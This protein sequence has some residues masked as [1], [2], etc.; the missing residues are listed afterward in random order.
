MHGE[1][2]DAPVAAEAPGRSAGPPWRV[3]AIVA[4]AVALLVVAL[5]VVLRSGSKD[6]A[7]PKTPQG[8]VIEL[9]D[10]SDANA[11]TA[12]AAVH[13]FAADRATLVQLLD[14]L[15]P[16]GRAGLLASLRTQGGDWLP[17]E[18]KHW[19]FPEARLGL[20]TLWDQCQRRGLGR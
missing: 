4:L 16:A 6:G 12:C 20:L 2:A 9:L 3:I 19:G 13:T 11:R 10:T 7:E 17:A 14:T 15:P 5:L 1:Q 8:L 18:A